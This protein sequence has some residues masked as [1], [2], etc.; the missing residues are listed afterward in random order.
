MKIYRLTQTRD[1]EC[2][3]QLFNDSISQDMFD[4]V[5]YKELIMDTIIKSE[6]NK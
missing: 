3:Y 6:I 4:K 5:I 2:I 1:V